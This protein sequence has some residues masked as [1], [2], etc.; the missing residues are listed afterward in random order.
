MMRRSASV[1]QATASLATRVQSVVA[2]LIA[3]RQGQAVRHQVVSAPAATR[4][5]VIRVSCTISS[6]VGSARLR[7]RRWRRARRCLRSS[8]RLFTRSAAQQ[9]PGAQ[10]GQGHRSGVTMMAAAGGPAGM[11]RPQPRRYGAAQDQAAT[12][13]ARWQHRAWHARRW[14]LGAR[15]RAWRACEG[16]PAQTRPPAPAGGG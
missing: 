16:W 14:P 4:P 2:F 9:Q 15:E 7:S 5:P 10:A 3:Q 11:S 1:S 12:I 8:G 6:P 13:G